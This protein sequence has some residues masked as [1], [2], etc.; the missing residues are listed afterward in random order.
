MAFFTYILR[1]RDGSYYVGHTDDLEHRI[2]QH[3]TGA[4]GGYTARR[5]PVTFLWADSFQT[6]DEAFA[7]ERKLKG[8]SRAKKEA[9]MAGDW[10]LVSQLA[11]CR[12]G[13]RAGTTGGAR[14]STSS[15]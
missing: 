1:C 10:G 11:R 4:L 3:Q 15:G 13:G 7:A 6:R 14:P 9:M 5:L 2:A 12:S 8:W